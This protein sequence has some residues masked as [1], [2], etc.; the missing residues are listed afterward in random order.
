MATVILIIH[1]M[2]ALALVALVLVQ[3]SEG[4]ALGIGGGGGGVM[5]GRGAGN[6]LT[7]ATG[8]LAAAFFV[9]SLTLGILATRGGGGS[10]LDQVAPAASGP[11]DSIVPGPATLVPAPATSGAGAETEVP[12]PAMSTPATP[13]EPAAPVVPRAQ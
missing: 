6:V 10:V 9:T 4:G 11:A 2:I 12:A 1:L 5:S 7:R 3:R 8:F 13:A